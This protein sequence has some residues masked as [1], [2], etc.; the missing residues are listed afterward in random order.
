MSALSYV[1]PAASTYVM[2][3]NIA[4]IVDTDPPRRDTLM[5]FDLW[6]SL[7]RAILDKLLNLDLERTCVVVMEREEVL[8]DVGTGK[9]EVPELTRAM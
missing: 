2:P 5:V 6:Y 8:G 9:G 3:K 7:Q 1:E 4:R